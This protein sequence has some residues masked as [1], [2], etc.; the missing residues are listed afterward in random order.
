MA[1]TGRKKPSKTVIDG[2][3]HVHASFNNDAGC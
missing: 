2:V 3:A 1:D